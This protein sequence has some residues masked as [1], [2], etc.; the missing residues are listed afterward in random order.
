MNYT[1]DAPFLGLSAGSGL[2]QAGRCLGRCRWSLSLRQPLISP[3]AVVGGSVWA[4]VG[5]WAVQ[6]AGSL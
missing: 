3:P 5:G 1:V 2:S 4:Q 6:W